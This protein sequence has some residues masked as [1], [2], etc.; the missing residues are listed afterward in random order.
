MKKIAL[1]LSRDQRIK[2]GSVHKRKK[3]CYFYFLF[4]LQNYHPGTYFLF[5]LQNYHT[6]T[7]NV[8]AETTTLPP[9]DYTPQTIALEKDT[10][11]A[12]DPIVTRMQE[13]VLAKLQALLAEP[14]AL[15][16]RNSAKGNPIVEV[17][18][19]PSDRAPSPIVLSNPIVARMQEQILADL[20]AQQATS[21][22]SESSLQQDDDAYIYTY[23]DTDVL[24]GRGGM[25]RHH[26]GNKWY[27]GAKSR[28]QEDYFSVHTN[29][30]KTQISHQLVDT[31]YARGGRFLEKLSTGTF[32]EVGRKRVRIKASQ[33]LR[34]VAKL[35]EF[36][37]HNPEQVVSLLRVVTAEAPAS[38][39][40]Q[41]DRAS[42]TTGSNKAE[43]TAN[44]IIMGM[45]ERVIAELAAVVKAESAVK[46]QG[47]PTVVVQK[48]PVDRSPPENTAN[49][50]IMGMQERVIAELAA[51]VKAE[52]AVK[53]Q[54]NPAAVVQKPPIDRSPPAIVLSTVEYSD[55]ISVARMQE[56]ILA[57][58]QAHKAT[59]SESKSS[60]Q[61]DDDAFIY[62]FTDLD[63]FMGRGGMARH[64]LGNKW[65]LAAKNRLQEN[66]FSAGTIEEKTQI[67]HQL[68]DT[69]YGRGGRFLEKVST[70][71]FVEVGRKRARIKASQALRE[72]SKR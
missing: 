72:A 37:T 38:P 68:V 47:N 28:L 39:T 33:A 70:G 25:A 22:E 57:K 21:S 62:N 69:V 8:V 41:N 14:Q 59:S 15:Q 63:V 56:Q 3:S 12:A 53:C 35:R 24:M 29:E 34:E 43:Y 7:M 45:Q 60:Q 36:R 66:Y 20:Q 64:H 32:V 46:Y 44:P 16:A 42:R 55:N 9:K 4:P 54:G 65:Y 71:T 67:S 23:T 6:G 11:P 19:L 48:P 50:I 49:P 61:H 18:K 27:L 31:V 52:S 1:P 30:E 40:P 58:L 13:N 5:P 2:V 17:P 10:S 26:P 51:V